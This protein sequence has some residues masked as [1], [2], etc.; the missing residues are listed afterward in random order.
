M[1]KIGNKKYVLAGDGSIRNGWISMFGKKYYSTMPNGLV[2]GWNY[3]DGAN[4]YFSP[5]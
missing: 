3:I 2:R 5:E 4:R 1:V